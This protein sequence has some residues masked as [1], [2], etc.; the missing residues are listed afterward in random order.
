[1]S[2]GTGT[3]ARDGFVVVAPGDPRARPLL[4][5]LH[6]EYVDRYGR[7]IGDAEMAEHSVDDFAA[8]AGGM[9]LLLEDGLTVAGGAFRR[10]DAATAELKRVWTDP[11]QRRRGLARRVLAELERLAA[12]AGYTRIYLETGNRQPEA[13]ALYRTHGYTALPGAQQLYPG[14]VYDLGFEKRL[15]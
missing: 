14:G 6:R 1:M 8:P 2:G 12:A 9:L 15:S 3:G 7:V 13:M 5:G 11:A 4:A 10:H